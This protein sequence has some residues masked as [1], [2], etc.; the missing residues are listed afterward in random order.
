MAPS[1][2]TLIPVNLPFGAV[3]S[4]GSAQQGGVSNLRLIANSRGYVHAFWVQ[5]GTPQ[6]DQL[7]MQLH[8]S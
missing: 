4:G 1:G 7:F 8:Y 6:N 5:K 2:G 3:P